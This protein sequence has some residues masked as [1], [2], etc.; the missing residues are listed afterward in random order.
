M[1]ECVTI[2]GTCWTVYRYKTSESLIL[3]WESIIH[4]R[5]L[6]NDV[7]VYSATKVSGFSLSRISYSFSDLNQTASYTYVTLFVHGMVLSLERSKGELA[8]QT[9]FRHQGVCVCVT[10]LKSVLYSDFWFTDIVIG[11]TKQRAAASPFTLSCERISLYD[12]HIG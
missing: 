5:L 2:D 7:T 9:L 1:D 11:R 3:K 10:G 12:V 6:L 8:D 4:I